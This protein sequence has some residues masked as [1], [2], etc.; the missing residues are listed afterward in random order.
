MT[1]D[2][3]KSQATITISNSSPGH[4]RPGGA[5]LDAKT[6]RWS[7]LRQRQAQ[8]VLDTNV[9]GSML[10]SR[11]AARV[12]AARGGGKIFL[13][14]GA[15]STGGTTANSAAYGASKR[16]LTQLKVLLGLAWLHM[17]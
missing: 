11:A 3:R 7:Q 12:M 15:G 2:T 14:D 4:L 5:R 13:V 6:S 9:L 16:A 10:G 17:M 1:F 8:E